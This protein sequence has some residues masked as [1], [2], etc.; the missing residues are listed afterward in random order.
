MEAFKEYMGTL[1]SKGQV[2][3]PAE[4]RQRLGIQPRGRVIFRIVDDRVELLPPPL[5]LADT[6]GAVKPRRQ[7]EDF[8]E[9]HDVAV[10]EHAQH[11]IEEMKS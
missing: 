7:P 5:N 11:V 8:Q 2:T 6:F 9:L 4:V 3:I 10:E 1:T